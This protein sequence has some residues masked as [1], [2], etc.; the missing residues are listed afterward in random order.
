MVHTITV[1]N[2]LGIP[3]EIKNG[4]GRVALT[5]DA[6]KTL[7]QTVPDLTVRVQSGAGMNSG[8][9][10]VQY[11]NAG[12][13]IEATAEQLYSKSNLIVK[14]KE[15]QQQDMDLIQPNS[16]LFGYLHLAPEPSLVRR[17]GEKSILSFALEH[18][19][20]FSGTPLLNPMSEIAGKIA[21]Q[22][23]AVYLYTSQGGRGILLG[24]L[25]GT[26]RG[27]VTILGAGCAGRT[28]AL[29]A[30]NMG[31]KVT[32]F[33]KSPE[34][35][36]FAHTL[37][38]NIETLFISDNALHDVLRTT[39]LL[40]GAI[41]V[42][43]ATAPKIVSRDMVSKMPTGSVI[44]DVSADQGGCIET[45]RPTTHSEPSYVDEGV[46]H[47]GIQNLPGA[48]PRTASTVLS[49]VMMQ[50]LKDLP[51]K[52]FDLEEA[53]RG[54]TLLNKSICTFDGIFIRT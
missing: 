46:I 8:F 43:G 21:V 4:E 16:T 19:E 42:P 47:V 49:G 33:D 31:A 51:G 2:Q 24:G 29:L 9:A 3:T 20:V 5:P 22:M 44:V 34:A 15:P 41:L 36:R 54:T 13:I 39:D 37:H 48:V 11:Q 50:Y 12:A 40:I 27:N 35:L 32:I 45:I 6:V 25:G 53:R 38:P 26:P 23:G 17:F 28:A 1:G 10:D 18:M 52:T 7:L 30:A 14:V